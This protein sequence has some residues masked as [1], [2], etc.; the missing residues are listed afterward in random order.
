MCIERRTLYIEITHFYIEP[1]TYTSI[2]QMHTSNQ[3]YIRWNCIYEWYRTIKSK[4]IRT[5]RNNPFILRI[6]S[7]CSSSWLEVLNRENFYINRNLGATD[8]RLLKQGLKMKTQ[9]GDEK[10]CRHETSLTDYELEQFFRFLRDFWRLVFTSDG[11]G[12]PV[13]SGVVRALMT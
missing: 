3:I 9:A 1:N 7:L 6:V 5:H 12:V 13:V 4:C 10:R 8:Q 11:L 2:L